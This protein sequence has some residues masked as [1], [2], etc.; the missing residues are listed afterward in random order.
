MGVGVPV[1]GTALF[2][3]I[4][5]GIKQKKNKKEKQEL[6]RELEKQKGN[7]TEM[8][9]ILPVPNKETPY[10]AIGPNPGTVISISKLSNVN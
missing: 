3:G 7:Y 10:L 5:F 8:P 2:L 1:A 4:F 6:K 9:D